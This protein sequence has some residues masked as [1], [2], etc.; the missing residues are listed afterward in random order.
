[1]NVLLWVSA[2][3]AVL[4]ALIY[5]LFFKTSG[6]RKVLVGVYSVFLGLFCC[7]SAVYLQTDAL[8]EIISW[9]Y[10]DT[11]RIQNVMILLTVVS[12]LPSLL[13][14]VF[15]FYKNEKAQRRFCFFYLILSLITD[16]VTF[17]TSCLQNKNYSIIMSL[18][19]P[20]FWLLSALVCTGLLDRQSK[21]QRIVSFILASVF[22]VV[23]FVAD[24]LFIVMTLST[25]FATSVDTA[26]FVIYGI[27][28]AV[29]GALG[30][31]M[32]ILEQVRS[33]KGA[34][35]KA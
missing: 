20:A 1:M 22:C 6:Y 12:L 7:F 34:L 16:T 32:L 4:C 5:I 2:G 18:F 33:P 29:I 14:V 11:L 13:L 24:I 8:S 26:S 25:G 31:V 19:V 28:I 23:I 17:I 3:L 30:L 27:L 10:L 15:S 9:Y 35:K 21:W